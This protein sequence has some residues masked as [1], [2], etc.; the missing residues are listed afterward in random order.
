MMT[1]AQTVLEFLDFWIADPVALSQLKTLLA[2][3]SGA[4]RSHSTP[5]NVWLAC[6][7]FQGVSRSSRRFANITTS[8]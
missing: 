5:W 1:V 2:F 6:S 8:F 4:H 3:G 7:D